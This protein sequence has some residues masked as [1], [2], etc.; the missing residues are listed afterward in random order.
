MVFQ[1]TL[2]FG[3]QSTGAYEITELVNQVIRDAGIHLGTCQ[4]F[5]HS[6]GASLLICDI[7]DAS[8]QSATAA[9]LAQLAPSTDE[10]ITRISLSLSMQS[11]PDAMRMVVLQTSLTVPV[12]NGRV[13]IGAWQG[14]YM[15]QQPGS[16]GERK[17]TLTLI[18]E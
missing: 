9:F 10:V 13:A 18:G 7:A 6:S 3:Q 11:I 12:G 5:V 17:L 4:L 14:I 1:D 15:W 8:T 16:P 2:T